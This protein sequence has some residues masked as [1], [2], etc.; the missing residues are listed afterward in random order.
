MKHVYILAQSQMQ[1]PLTPQAR[2]GVIGGT[3]QLC[4]SP[5]GCT[6]Q[7]LGLLRNLIGAEGG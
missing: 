4:L 5:I 2:L 3:A 6:C 7:K 1:V